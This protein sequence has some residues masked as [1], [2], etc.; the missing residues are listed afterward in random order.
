M[1]NGA[2]HAPHRRKTGYFCTRSSRR[3]AEPHAVRVLARGDS[4]EKPPIRAASSD[5]QQH[6]PNTV[7]APRPGGAKVQRPFAQGHDRHH[8]RRRLLLRLRH[9]DRA[10]SRARIT[11]I[12]LYDSA[13]RNDHTTYAGS[14]WMKRVRWTSSPPT[15][16]LGSNGFLP[17][18]K[19][20]RLH[21][22]CPCT[23]CLCSVISG[24]VM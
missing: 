7:A 9:L 21:R 14:L 16:P 4:S 8:H 18:N 23:T 15:S 12:R 10:R 5:A 24:A 17:P 1:R 3:R 6:F 20:A 22:A 13:A 2:P 19:H 11:S